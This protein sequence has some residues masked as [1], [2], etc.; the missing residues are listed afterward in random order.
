MM[1]SH[2][3]LSCIGVPRIIE[4]TLPEYLSSPLS[5]T[6]EQDDDWELYSEF[7]KTSRININ[8]RQVFPPP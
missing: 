2:L 5:N 4:D 3:I 1:A 6:D 8:V 7:L